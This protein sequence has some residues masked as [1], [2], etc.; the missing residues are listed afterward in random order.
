MREK[1][2]Q[3]CAAEAEEGG[4][5]FKGALD[6]GG[7]GQCTSLLRRQGA[8]DLGRAIQSRGD[9]GYHSVVKPIERKGS[10]QRCQ[11]QRRLDVAC[12]R[13]EVEKLRGNSEVRKGESVSQD[14]DTKFQQVLKTYGRGLVEIAGKL[15]PDIIDV[16]SGIILS[17]I[18]LVISILSRQFKNNPALVGEFLQEVVEGLAQRIARG[19]VP[20]NLLDVH[21]V[22]LAH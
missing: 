1:T 5:A 20:S 21:F 13:A 17:V 2:G 18:D 14:G 3:V 16:Y 6:L 11:H 10:P 19:H 22:A 9:V 4:L 15:N 7:T 8:L 12:V